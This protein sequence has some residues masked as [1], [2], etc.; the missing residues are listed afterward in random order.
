[1]TERTIASPAASWYGRS[2]RGVALRLNDSSDDSM[3]RDA[4]L[5]LSVIGG[6]L[7]R[8]P[9]TG[10]GSRHSVPVRGRITK[11]TTERREGRRGWGWGPPRGAEGMS[12]LGTSL[13][14]R[15]TWQHNPVDA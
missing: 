3:A 6:L 12:E 5:L 13:A 1:M 7:L 10:S 2:G 15:T 4:R 11:V 9:I 14:R 8:L